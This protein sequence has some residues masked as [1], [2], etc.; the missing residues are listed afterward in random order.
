MIMRLGNVAGYLIGINLIA[1]HLSIYFL[2]L[3]LPEISAFLFFKELFMYPYHNKIRQRIKNGELVA[4]I[5]SEKEEF[6]FVLIFSTFPFTRP[7]RHQA[8]KKYLDL[9]GD[10]L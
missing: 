5:Q 6:A 4:I 1:Q 10:K 2:E 3:L 9:I 8:V 7:I